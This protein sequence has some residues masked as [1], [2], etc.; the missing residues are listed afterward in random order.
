[1]WRWFAVRKL[2]VAAIT[3][4]QM[5]Y[6]FVWWLLNDVRHRKTG[7]LMVLRSF[8]W[9]RELVYYHGYVTRADWPGYKHDEEFD[10]IKRAIESNHKQLVLRTGNKRTD[11][12]RTA[13][14]DEEGAKSVRRICPKECTT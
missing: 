13:M 7:K 11:A 4:K 2:P 1:M 3:S 10:R 9:I 14:R 8:K 12:E 6:D 5:I